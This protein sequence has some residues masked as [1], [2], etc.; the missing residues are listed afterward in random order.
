MSSFA[1]FMRMIN[2]INHPKYKSY[3]QIKYFLNGKPDWSTVPIKTPV[4][5]YITT[6]GNF[7]TRKTKHEIKAILLRTERKDN[8]E[9]PYSFLVKLKDLE[10]TNQKLYY[11]Y[12]SNFF[13]EST[14]TIYYNELKLDL[15]N[16]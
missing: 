1:N 2:P 14:A 6:Q 10:E 7:S 13:S 4:K 8:P 16:D 12:K 9:S 15:P 5:F 11:I 3:I